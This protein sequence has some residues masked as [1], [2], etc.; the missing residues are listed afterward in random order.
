[1]KNILIVIAIMFSFNAHAKNMQEED[2]LCLGLINWGW[3]VIGKTQLG[4]MDETF[5]A[6]KSNYTQKE[7]NKNIRAIYSKKADFKASFA[8]GY[9]KVSQVQQ[10]LAMC[11][12]HAGVK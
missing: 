6:I 5:T 9:L 4:Y 2:V 10:M 11:Q 7:F 12:Q 3:E 8:G 1:M